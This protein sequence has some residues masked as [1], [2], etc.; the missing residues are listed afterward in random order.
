MAKITV[1]TIPEI[2]YGEYEGYEKI[3]HLYNSLTDDLT[4]AGKL[5]VGSLN[6]VDQHWLTELDQ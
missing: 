4:T 3:P 2:N 1:G 6:P 5:K